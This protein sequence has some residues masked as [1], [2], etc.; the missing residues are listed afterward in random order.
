[1][2]KYKEI[3]EI[4]KERINTHVYTVDEKLPDQ[5]TLAKEFATS[6]VTIKKALDLLRAAGLLYTI[7]GSGSYI[8]RN[9]L[10]K[11]QTSI[12]IGHN[13]GLTTAVQKEAQLDNKVITFTVRFPDEKERRHLLIDRE[14]PVYF[15]QRLRIIGGK[16]YSLENTVMPVHL[17]K[18]ITEE[19]LNDSVYRYIREELGIIFKDNRQ[20]VRAS[21]PTALD[22]VHLDC[23]ETDPVLEVEKIM[24]LT[25]GTPVEYSIVHH[26]Y[27]MVEMLFEN[28]DH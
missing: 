16:P 19:V 17:I 14:T 5:Q 12:Q 26:R 1:M 23:K 10:M 3:A 25:T 15:Y 21:K 22:Q 9:A 7:Q 8:K 13:V 24:Y 20:I 27:D 6:R 2:P 11:A 18:G 4:I 28:Q